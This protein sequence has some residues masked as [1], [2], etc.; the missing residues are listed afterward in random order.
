MIVKFHLSVCP[1]GAYSGMPYKFALERIDYSDLASGKVFLSASGHPAFPVRLASEIFQRCRAIRAADGLTGRLTLFDPCCGAAYH[2]AVLAFL[3]GQ[4][5][6]EIVASDID[7][8]VLPLA[9][10]NLAMLSTAGFDRRM[11]ELAEMRNRFGKS[12][13]A[14]AL[15]AAGRLRKKLVE[16]TA[17][18]EIKTR[19]FRADA[20]KRDS[21]SVGL[22]GVPVDVVI[23]DVPY[24]RHSRW[25]DSSTGD[26][27]P[28]G[29]LLEALRPSLHSGS[30]AAIL[31]DK[32]QKAS[33]EEYQRIERLSIGKR[34][35]VFWRL[36]KAPQA[37]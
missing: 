26:R 6:R 28:I 27:D 4:S 12:S 30:V 10:R 21:L 2:L 31:S 9:E 35:A 7:P 13:H 16:M 36:K 24:G 25:Q 33:H 8:L 17:R 1:C 23:T 11:I 29:L 19:S 3:H 14:E 37:G 34:Q 15:A 20:L 22:K 5:L 32:R 18:H